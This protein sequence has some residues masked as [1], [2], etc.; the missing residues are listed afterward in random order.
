M[1]SESW[2]AWLAFAIVIWAVVYGFI[3]K[4][5][6]SKWCAYV[7]WH[8]PAQKDT[9]G[10]YCPIVTEGDKLEYMVFSNGDTTKYADIVA[11]GTFYDDTTIIITRN[12]WYF[13]INRVQGGKCENDSTMEYIR[14]HP[15]EEHNDE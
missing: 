9:F 3:P 11:G 1:K 15:P 7:E 4:R 12:N 5:K 2:G 14:H 13:Y 8:D 6:I 10:R